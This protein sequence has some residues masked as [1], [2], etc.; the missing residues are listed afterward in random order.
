MLLC[1]SAVARTDAFRS[2]TSVGGVGGVPNKQL[3][4]EHKGGH[5]EEPENLLDVT[6]C[7]CVAV[8]SVDLWLFDG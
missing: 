7:S 2:F 8:N 6:S 1:N 4:A 5:P 3:Q